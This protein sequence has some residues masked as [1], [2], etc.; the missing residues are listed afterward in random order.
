MRWVFDTDLARFAEQVLP[1]AEREPVINNVLYTVVDSRASGAVEPEPNCLWARCLDDHG[2]LHAVAIRTG[3]HPLLVSPLSEAAAKGLAAV[4]PGDVPALT[5]VPESVRP[6]VAATGRDAEL[7]VALRMYRLDA[8]TPSAPVPGVLRQAT[9]A[10]E[11][12]AVEWA[13]G[14]RDDAHTAVDDPYTLVGRL[15]AAQRLW[16]WDRAGTPVSMACTSQPTA[17][18]VRVGL[19]YTPPELRR[20]GY[21]SACVAAVSQRMLDDGASACM[22]Y[23]DLSN[24]TSNAIYQA[25]GYRPVADAETW[26]FRAL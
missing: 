23:T 24:P 18:V 8:V 2:N 4:L 17:G 1:W 22:L 3:P 19:V 15:I 25:L 14:F 20:R 13:V 12:L 26:E 6:I 11:A 7:A 10:D 5:G 9:E 16:L 21:A